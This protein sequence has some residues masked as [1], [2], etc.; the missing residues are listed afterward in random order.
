MFEGAGYK[1]AVGTTLQ[2]DVLEKFKASREQ[3]N[4]AMKTAATKNGTAVVSTVEK[5]AKELEATDPSIEV[6]RDF[7]RSMVGEAGTLVIKAS[8]KEAIKKQASVVNIGKIEDALRKLQQDDIYRFCD[9]A[10]QGLV[11]NT[12]T[13][14]KDL[15]SG[16]VPNFG[17]NPNDWTIEVRELLAQLCTVQHGGRKLTGQDA[18]THLFE[19][20]E[21]KLLANKATLDDY[22]EPVRFAWLLQ[23]VEQTTLQAHRK[24]LQDKEKKN[25]T[26]FVDEAASSSSAKR[27]G[28]AASSAGPAAASDAKKPKT[29]LDAAMAMFGR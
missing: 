23:P 20:A 24:Q 12:L 4:G 9:S 17:A 14:L 26:S 21:K 1:L 11:V 28:G 10:G 6:V 18:A 13:F 7:F 16:R 19:A 29:E 3:I 25:L 27:K 5:E 8:I 15:H 2:A 22:K